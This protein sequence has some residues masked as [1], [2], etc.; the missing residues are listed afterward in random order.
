MDSTVDWATLCSATRKVYLYERKP[1]V[2]YWSVRFSF[3][4]LLSQG[5]ALD[6][7][8]GPCDRLG[9]NKQ[10]AADCAAFALRIA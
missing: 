8:I 9:E 1:S 7:L 2:G 10:V 3:F 4:F 5:I 6:W